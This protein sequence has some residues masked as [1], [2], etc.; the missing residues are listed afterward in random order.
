MYIGK[1]FRLI[2]KKNKR[3]EMLSILKIKTHKP[4]KIYQRIWE[5]YNLVQIEG[6]S[7]NYGTVW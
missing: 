7:W 2:N 6:G 4:Y 5:K 1:N 3:E